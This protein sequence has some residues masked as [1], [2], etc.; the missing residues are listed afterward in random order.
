M[1]R[2]SLRLI[3]AA[4]CFAAGVGADHLVWR[5]VESLP[6][7]EVLAPAPMTCEVH[8]EVM[9]L[10]APVKYMLGSIISI[11]DRTLR[12]RLTSYPNSNRFGVPLCVPQGTPVYYCPA[13]RAEQ[14]RWEKQRGSTLAED[15]P[16]VGVWQPDG[17]SGR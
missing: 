9:S 12:R 8:G 5:A 1:K 17:D 10:D 11:H 14:A 3:V 6:E 2:L 4:V 7:A 13:C 15:V 16:C